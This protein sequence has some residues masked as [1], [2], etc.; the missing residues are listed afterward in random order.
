MQSTDESGLRGLALL[1]RNLKLVTRAPHALRSVDARYGK[2]VANR[3]AL[4]HLAF[5]PN[6]GV[7]FNRVKKNANSA[8][9]LLLHEME[10]GQSAVSA[11][12][13]DQTPNLFEL[14]RAELDRLDRFAVFTTI[15]DPYS[16]VLSAFLDK[17]RQEAYRRKH[18]AFD[19]TPDGFD[20]FLVWLEQGGLKRDAH[21]DLQTKLLALPLDRFDAVLRFE[22]LRADFAAFL[23]LRGLWLPEDALVGE[24]RGD[25]GKQT[26]ARNRQA[27]FYSPERALRVARLFAPDF[28]ALGYDP[29]FGS[30]RA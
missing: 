6:L 30:R 18:G 4:R 21:W 12:A 24:H 8:L 22:T 13:K 29:D 26:G 19:L 2:G 16:R 10:T 7:A 11:Q 9:I 25:T 3:A 15:R 23:A 27:E 1:G 20:A 28:D 17:F 14:P 5:F